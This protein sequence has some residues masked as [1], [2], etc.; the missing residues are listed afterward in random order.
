MK[1]RDNLTLV[2]VAVLGLSL[3]TG[4]LTIFWTVRESDLAPASDTLQFLLQGQAFVLAACALAYYSSRLLLRPM[5]SILDGIA[6]FARGRFDHRIQKSKIHELDMVVEQLNRMAGKLQELDTMKTEFV[7]NVSHELR[8]PMAAMEEYIEILLE[9]SRRAGR[10]RDNLL[11]IQDN[12]ARLRALVENLLEMSRIEAGKLPL[13]PEGFDLGAEIQDI[14]ALLAPRLESRGLALETDLSPSAGKVHA[15]RG[16]VKQ[17]LINLVDNAV[18][19]N[20]KGGSV[21]VRAAARNGALRVTVE[22][23]GPGI[24]P[25]HMSGL[26]ERFR[27]LPPASPETA[28]AGGVGLGLAI[29]RGLARAMGGDI[30]AESKVGR[31]SAFTLSLPLTRNDS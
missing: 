31:G 7:A 16:K 15:D 11:R 8:S 4:L 14:C 6:N 3:E 19:Y 2:M 27:R 25:E 22:D 20:R 28:K 30:T 9:G 17:I 13:S 1:L 26:F 29:S 10:N 21:T 24:R 5:E 23:T 18:K 12:L